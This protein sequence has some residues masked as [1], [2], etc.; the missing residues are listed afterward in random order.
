MEKDMTQTEIDTGTD[1]LLASRQGGVVT[2]T[3]NRADSRNALTLAM[4]EAMAA[5]LERAETDNGVR[6]VVLTGAGKGF[7]SGGDVKGFAS[8]ANAEP[9]LPDAAIRLQRRLQRDTAG[10]LR[11]MPK[12]TLAAINGAA[13][14]AGLALALAC[15][16]RIMVDSAVMVT[17]FS[18]VGL[19][20]DF[21]GTYLLSHLLGP[22]KARELYFLSPKLSAEDALAIGLVNRLVGA[23]EFNASVFQTAQALASGPTIALGYMKENLNRALSASFEECM[24]IEA[25]HHIHCFQTADHKEAAAAFMRREEPIFHGR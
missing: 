2:L 9:M 25:T 23:G 12:P 8:A 1:E 10:R 14:G 19:S 16:M 20:G 7:C 21:G 22:A 18:R 24:D 17:S 15:D 13:A 3:M 4:V 5:Q 6:C 11:H